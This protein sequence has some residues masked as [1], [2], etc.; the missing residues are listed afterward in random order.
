M[1]VF[2]NSVRKPQLADTTSGREGAL[3]VGTDSKTHLGNATTAEAAFTYLDSYV[4]T[5][6]ATIAAIE[7]TLDSIDDELDTKCDL[8]GLV[9]FHQPPNDPFEIRTNYGLYVTR[10]GDIIY[11]DAAVQVSD[12]PVVAAG[13]GMN[14]THV[15]NTYTVNCTVTVPTLPTVSGGQGTTV[16][17]SGSDYKIHSRE[18]RVSL[19]DASTVTIDCAN[20]NRFRLDMDSARSS[21]TLALSN[22]SVGQLITVV[23]RQ[24][25]SGGNTV[26]WPTGTVHPSAVAP[27]LTNTAN[28]CDVFTLECLSTGVYLLYG[29]GLDFSI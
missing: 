13:T 3:L 18:A 2:N 22:I 29:N 25:S 28:H 14:V 8:F 5:T 1:T 4:V 21:R 7:D 10:Q 27:T 24:G 15:G 23:L 11:V 17:V 16:V 19:T 6:A 26:T 9:D 20:D 12:L